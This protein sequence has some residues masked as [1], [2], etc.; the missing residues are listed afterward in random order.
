MRCASSAPVGNKM[1]H[2]GPAADV[3]TSMNTLCAVTAKTSR[4]WCHRIHRI[5]EQFGAHGARIDRLSAI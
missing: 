5:S 1:A 4:T 3:T 2:N